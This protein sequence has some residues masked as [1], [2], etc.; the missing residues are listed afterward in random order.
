[1]F[2]TKKQLK[3]GFLLVL[4]C[5]I[6]CH[7][8]IAQAA[9]GKKSNS[10]VRLQPIIANGSDHSFFDTETMKYIKD[11]YRNAFIL[12]VWIRTND[13]NLNGGYNLTQYYLRLSPRQYQQ[14]E[15]I[16][17]DKD[18]N[19]IESKKT[20]YSDN[21]W[22]DII[23]ESVADGW[24]HEVVKYAKENKIISKGSGKN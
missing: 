24:Y 5:C 10:Q 21:R 1:L 7:S 17:Y 15:S 18:L 2:Y 12:E 8:F 14:M 11:P 9:L 4:M 16:D 22:K 23:P 20:I 13:N 6:V 3:L 19:M